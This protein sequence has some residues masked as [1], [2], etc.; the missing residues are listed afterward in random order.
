MTDYIE[1]LRASKEQSE[2]AQKQ[3][4]DAQKQLDDVQKDEGRTAGQK[5]AKQYAEYDQLKKVVYSDRG[6]VSMASNVAEF[7][8]IEEDTV[9]VTLTGNFLVGFVAGATE[10]WNEIEDK[11]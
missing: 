9:D 8:G 10:V 3:S 1:R 11:I 7:Y 6:L 4:A 5:W 2:E